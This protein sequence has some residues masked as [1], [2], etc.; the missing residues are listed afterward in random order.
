MEPTDL[1]LFQTYN[2]FIF[3]TRFFFLFALGNVEIYLFYYIPIKGIAMLPKVREQEQTG[4]TLPAIAVW[5]AYLLTLRCAR[6][7]S[8]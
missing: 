5:S 6:N 8:L 3:V 4:Q 1:I 7:V 2:I